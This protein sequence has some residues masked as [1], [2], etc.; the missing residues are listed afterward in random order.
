MDFSGVLTGL[1]ASGVTIAMIAA[2]GIIALVGFAF[3]G[4]TV[5]GTFFGDSEMD[6]ELREIEIARRMD[7]GEDIDDDDLQFMGMSRDDYEEARSEVSEDS[8]EDADEDSDE[9]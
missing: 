3:W 5:L 4:S 9:R 1:D 6:D 2:A 7:F 8:D